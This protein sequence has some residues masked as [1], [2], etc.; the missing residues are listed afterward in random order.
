MDVYI[1]HF[2]SR[3]SSIPVKHRFTTMQM[4]IGGAVLACAAYVYLQRRSQYKQASAT[5]A[6]TDNTP[7]VPNPTLSSP[8]GQTTA[9]ISTNPS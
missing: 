3:L 4:T 6:A 7:Q 8:M 2:D 9:A 1:P 5:I